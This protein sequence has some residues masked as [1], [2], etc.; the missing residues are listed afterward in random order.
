[1]AATQRLSTGRSSAF[2]DS[3][4]NYED[5][6]IER[7]STRAFTVR[8]DTPDDFIV[9]DTTNRR[10]GISGINGQAVFT[11]AFLLHAESETDPAGLFIDAY[12][13]A[14]QP[15]MQLRKARGTKAAPTA[16]QSNDE[17][18]IWGSR[19]Y[20]ATAF[21]GGSRASI[22][23]IASEN[24]TDA[25]QG[26]RIQIHTNANGAAASVE[27]YRFDQNGN[28]IMNGA[29]D[30]KPSIDDNGNVGTA[31]NRFSLVRAVTVTAGDLTFE[32]G[33]RLTEDYDDDGI[34][35]QDRMGRE[36]FAIRKSGLYFMG[37]KIQSREELVLA[38]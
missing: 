35:L 21:S 9:V 29:F 36:M 31:A 25:A 32:N 8:D 38:S 5:I 27:R 18:G 23:M 10:L 20:G 28:L 1:M 26:M 4:I 7:L 12:G 33:W 17:L 34:I 11:P 19:G 16:V 13:V 37:R 30:L 24:W 22:R 15:Q 6:S 3:P 14:V 2:L